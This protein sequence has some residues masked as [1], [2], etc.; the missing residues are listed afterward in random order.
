MKF[1]EDY[2]V[3]P[4]GEAMLNYCKKIVEGTLT[5]DNKIEQ[6]EKDIAAFCPLVKK[7]NPHLSDEDVREVVCKFLSEFLRGEFKC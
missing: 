7:N 3:T 2:T 4:K 6:Y 1:K 5:E